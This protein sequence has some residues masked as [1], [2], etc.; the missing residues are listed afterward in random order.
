MGP[1]GAGRAFHLH[2]DP[3]AFAD[4]VA[5]LRAHD[6][7]GYTRTAGLQ[8]VEFLRPQADPLDFVVAYYEG[9]A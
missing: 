6:I 2:L 9:L 5:P 4:L 7:L 3:D 8:D 1:G